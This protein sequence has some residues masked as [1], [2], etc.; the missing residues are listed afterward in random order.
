MTR[1]RLVVVLL[2]L[3]SLVVV[4]PTP[5]FAVPVFARKYGV[6][7]TMCH[8][9]VPRLNDFGARFRQNGYQLPGRENEERTV[10]QGPAPFAARI[11][12]GWNVRNYSDVPAAIAVPP[13]DVNQL[14]LNGLDLLSAGVVAKNIG[15]FAVYVPEIKERSGVVGQEGTLE[16]A[17]VVFSN[18]GTSWFNV[19]AGR[20]EPA[21]VA[22]SAKRRLTFT[23]YAIYD[24]AFPGGLALSDTQTG[25]EVYGQTRWPGSGFA[26]GYAAGYMNGA[27]TNQDDSPADFYG[28][29]YVVIGAGEGQTTG[30]RIGLVAYQGKARPT[31]GDS[32]CFTRYGI[33]ASLNV[34]QWNLALQYLRGTDSKELW[35][36]TGDGTF[37]GGFAELSW[38]PMTRLVAFARYDLVNIPDFKDSDLNPPD[39]T[40]TYPTGF[41]IGARYYMVD[42]LALHGEYTSRTLDFSGSSLPD[43]K[44]TFYTLSIDFSF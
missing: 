17:S 34:K 14:Q 30:Q 23:S 22:I 32:A 16:M 25:L 37:S 21:Y 41:T 5:S 12:A 27:G 11:S 15:Y 31:Q 40:V 6:Q 18:I 38:Q 20:M 7:C 29:A 33:D 1:Q 13:T 43:E 35:N 9:A 28:R 39:P 44:E 26:L 24:Y 4:L 3:V 2:A 10:L 19:R 42:Q 36:A 8:S